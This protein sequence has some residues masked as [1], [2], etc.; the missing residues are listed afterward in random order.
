[1]TCMM[2]FHR[3]TFENI[4]T[5]QHATSIPASFLCLRCPWVRLSIHP[6]SYSVLATAKKHK[7]NRQTQSA[8]NCQHWAQSSQISRT[9]QIIKERANHS[10]ATNATE[11]KPTSVTTN[12]YNKQRSVLMRFVVS[13]LAVEVFKVHALLRP[14]LCRVSQCTL[15]RV[16]QQSWS[17]RHW[18]L[19]TRPALGPYEK[20]P[21][22]S[23]QS[24]DESGSQAM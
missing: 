5:W 8:G 19:C 20:K 11:Q 2:Q 7:T 16:S 15:R 18:E 24:E 10:K 14:G 6:S 3:A 12:S 13:T 21:M 9:S 17:I 23:G 4:L 1:M 22:V